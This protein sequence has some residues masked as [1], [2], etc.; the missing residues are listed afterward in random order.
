MSHAT[1]IDTEPIHADPVRGGWG[2]LLAALY[3][4][5]APAI[6]LMALFTSAPTS[7]TACLLT[8]A[9]VIGACIPVY[10]LCEVVRRRI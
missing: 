9:I 5:Y 4:L 8:A 6:A 2:R 3:L 1:A 7:R 10:A